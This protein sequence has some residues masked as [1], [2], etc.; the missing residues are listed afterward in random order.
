MRRARLLR[1]V[2]LIALSAA[3][4]PGDALFGQGVDREVAFCLFYFI[5]LAWRG[6]PANN[7][8]HLIIVTV[9]TTIHILPT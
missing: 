6:K 7:Y 9:S 1:L 2:A 4:A 8:H 5:M 3:L